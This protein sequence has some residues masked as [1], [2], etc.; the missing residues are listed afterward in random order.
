MPEE[1]PFLRE[2]LCPLGVSQLELTGFDPDTLMHYLS[3]APRN[4]QN[5]CKLRFNIRNSTKLL[6]PHHEEPG[7]DKLSVP[8]VEELALCPPL[9]WLGVNVDRHDLPRHDDPDHPLEYLDAV[10]QI[11]SLTQL[12]IRI[13]FAESS[14]DK[15]DPSSLEITNAIAAFHHIQKQKRGFPLETM[16]IRHDRVNGWYPKRNEVW[17]IWPFG[18]ESDD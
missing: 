6:I 3:Y 14:M 18:S 13:P 8:Q 7:R 10:A 16:V 5:L 1:D 9:S 11:G 2:F 4:R 15:N 12:N 17:L